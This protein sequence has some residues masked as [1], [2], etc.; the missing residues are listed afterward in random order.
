V[1]FV[2]NAWTYDEIIGAGSKKYKQH[3]H[4]AARN[5]ENLNNNGNQV[6]NTPKTL[7]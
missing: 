1:E 3:G 6:K 4:N 5:R 2:D 7:Y